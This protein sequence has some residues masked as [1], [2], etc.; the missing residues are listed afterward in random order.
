MT[1]SLAPNHTQDGAW[2]TQR[3]DRQGRPRLG[4]AAVLA[5][6]VGFLAG[7]ILFLPWD[8]IWNAALRRLAGRVEGARIVWQNVDRAGPL[9]FR[10]NGLSV[11]VPGSPFAP[12]AQWLDVRLGFSPL[13]SIKAESGGSLVKLVLLDTGAFDFD[14]EVNLAA[15][16]RRDIKG[17]ATVRG[18]GQFLHGKDELEK[19]FIELRSRS[20]SM[21]DGLWLGEASLALEYRDGAM[22][23]R[24]FTMREPVQIRAEGTAAV[25]FGAVLTSPFAVSGEMIRGHDTIPFSTQGQLG[26]FLGGAALPE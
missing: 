20:L 12:R 10:I 1:E 19:G 25:R 9:S 6:L 5:A 14:G 22:R 24:T 11:E 7:V 13:V 21:P 2:A 8:S 17:V 16:G 3:P 15:L 4:G 23:I 18:D 26:D